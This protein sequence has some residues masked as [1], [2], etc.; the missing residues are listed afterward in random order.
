MGDDHDTGG[1]DTTSYDTGHHHD[2]HSSHHHHQVDNTVLTYM[3]TQ[4]AQDTQETTPGIRRV[5]VKPK[6]ITVH[7]QPVQRQPTQF[8][9]RQPKYTNDECCIVA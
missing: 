9:P 3:I 1:Y 8:K 7:K 2:H 4:A 5:D 6:T